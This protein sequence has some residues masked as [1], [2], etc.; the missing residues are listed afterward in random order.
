MSDD[1]P[2][3]LAEITAKKANDFQ[4]AMENMARKIAKQEIG[5]YHIDVQIIAVE[6]SMKQLE[7]EINA[8]KKSKPK[9][10]DERQ[11]RASAVMSKQRD[12]GLYAKTLKSL[13]EDQK[14]VGIY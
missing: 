2:N 4:T 3:P 10:Q 12:L 5:K 9:T 6:Q 13:K 1:K 11:Y 8:F 14:K 7:D